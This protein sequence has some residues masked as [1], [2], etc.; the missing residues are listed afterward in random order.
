MSK[1][2]KAS[3]NKKEADEEENFISRSQRK[4]EMEALQILGKQLS[5]LPKKHLNSLELDPTLLLAIE[6][7]QRFTSNEGKRRQMQYIGKIMRT[8]DGEE[9]RLKFEGLDAEQRNQGRSH[10]LAEQWRDRLLTDNQDEVTHFFAEYPNIEGQT[11]RQLVRAAVLEK[12]KR[13]ADQSEKG[14][15]QTQGRA[16][17]KFVRESIDQALE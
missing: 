6:D 5:E 9:I 10:I 4:R 8:V 1:N 15:K 3:N 17:F 2:K 12:K 7:Y 11:F 13:D 16:L 14:K